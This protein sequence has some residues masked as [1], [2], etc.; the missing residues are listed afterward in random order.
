MGRVCGEPLAIRPECALDVRRLGIGG[1]PQHRRQGA[2]GRRQLWTSSTIPVV[3]LDELRDAVKEGR[4]VLLPLEQALMGEGLRL[5]REEVAEKS[6]VELEFLRK[7]WRA[8]GMTEPEEDEKMFTEH[9]VEVAKIVK[10]LLD[11]GIPENEMLQVSRVIGMTMSQLAAANRGLGVRVFAEEG[12]SELRCG[13]AVRRVAEWGRSW[14]RSSSTRSSSTCASRSARRFRIDRDLGGGRAGLETAIAFADLVGF[15][16]LGERLDP[17]EL[18]DLTD[19]L[20]NMASEVAGGPVRLVKL[21][22]DAVMLTSQPRSPC[23]TPRS[24]WSP[25]PSSVARTSRCFGRALPMG[26]SSPAAATLR[27]AG[28]PGKP[29]HQHGAGGQRRLRPS[30]ARRAQG[31]LQVV[32][33]GR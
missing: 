11:I 30:D 17:A 19:E 6:G 28:E 33:R 18:G 26:G 16:K 24:S 21:I 29:D 13:E 25:R 1:P 9:D 22:G 27:A 32:V 5:T 2:R 15:T 4:L 14:A 3:S 10:Q 20:S 12:D 7:N 8:L 31:R 23:S